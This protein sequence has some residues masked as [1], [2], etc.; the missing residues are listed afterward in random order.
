MCD[1]FHSSARAPA[2]RPAPPSQTLASGRFER[3]WRR[4]Q[5]ALLLLLW[6]CVWRRL[7]LSLGPELLCRP[8]SSP[9][10]LPLA[11]SGGEHYRGGYDRRAIHIRQGAVHIRQGV[12]DRRAW[13]SHH[14]PQTERTPCT[15]PAPPPAAGGAAASS[16][17]LDATTL[18][19]L[20]HPSGR[21]KVP[22]AHTCA[23]PWV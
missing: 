6:E 20:V 1:R 9:A 22:R 7:H 19:R 4:P 13:E 10:L 15:A 14:H 5:E 23:A 18:R 17:P 8:P 16:S 12:Y 21:A 11:S 3:T 2:D